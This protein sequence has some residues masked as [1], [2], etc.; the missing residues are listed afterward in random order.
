[1]AVSGD[2]VVGGREI[3]LDLAHSVYKV[4]GGASVTMRPAAEA[5][6]P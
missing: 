3:E 1:M 5:A 4:R 2:D 6:K